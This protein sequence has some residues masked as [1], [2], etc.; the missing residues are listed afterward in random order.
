MYSERKN[1]LDKLREQGFF[2]NLQKTESYSEADNDSVFQAGEILQR[3]FTRRNAASTRILYQ[4]IYIS[5]YINYIL[6]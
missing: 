6:L 2:K 1:V 4:V 3:I 5:G